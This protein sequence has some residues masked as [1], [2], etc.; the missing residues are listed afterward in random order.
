M[1]IYAINNKKMYKYTKM[2]YLRK[3]FF[4][5]SLNIKKNSRKMIFL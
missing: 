4:L 5:L 1:N 3:A 2:K